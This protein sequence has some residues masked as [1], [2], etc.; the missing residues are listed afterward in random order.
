MVTVLSALTKL[1]YLEI[2]FEN[3]GAIRLAPPPPPPPPPP[4]TRAVLPVL[5][6]FK[7]QDANE[8]SE[9]L[10]ARIE[11]PHLESLSITYEYEPRV[12]DIRQVITHSLPLGPFLFAEILSLKRST[13]VSYRSQV[14]KPHLWDRYAPFPHYFPVLPNSTSGATG[15]FLSTTRIQIRRT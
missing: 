4:L 7:F 12:F 11:V 3:L 10:L 2:S 1:T 15:P 5:T 13:F 14:T 8:Y 6:V 9:N